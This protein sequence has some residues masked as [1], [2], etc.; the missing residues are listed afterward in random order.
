MKLMRFLP[1]FRKAY[2]MLEMLEARESWSRDEIEAFQLDRVNALWEQASR[3]VPYYRTLAAESN[4][5]PRFCSLGEFRATVPVLPKFE[6]RARRDSF[7]SEKAERGCWEFTSGSTGTPTPV[8]WGKEAKHRTL[9]AQ[10][11]FRAMWG[12][13]IFDRMAVLWGHAASFAP[14]LAGLAARM[15]MPWRDWLRNWI[16]LSAYY[17][18]R[19]DLRQYLRQIANFRPAAIYAYSTAAYLLALEAQA[20]GFTCDSLKMVNL[21]AEPVF[22]YM[23]E[24]VE[25][26]FGVPAVTEYGSVECGF[27][28]GEWRDR[29]LRVREDGVLMET[30]PRNDGRYDIV[31]SVLSNPSFPL[32][33]YA[34]GDVTSAALEFPERGFAILTNVTGRYNDLV[35]SRSGRYIHPLRLDEVFEHKDGIRRWRVQQDSSGTL[36][37][38]IE[39]H[40]DEVSIDRGKLVRELED[41]VE[42]FAV[43]LQVATTLPKT[44]AG[45]H[46][47]ITSDLVN[48]PTHE[49]TG[50]IEAPL[51]QESQRSI[52]DE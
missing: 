45:K 40:N 15:S 2:R 6:V 39:L 41:V 52:V 50:G 18:G 51:V 49:A 48:Q 21:A 36:S 4:L 46:R 20:T 11:R 43:S 13:D 32:I 26:A 27:L 9:R 10:Y 16:R 30:L 38:V 19:D 14:G 23:A 1:R 7:F 37:V 47:W 24:A 3:H 17:L 12:I 25:R 31:V 8:Y 34:I 33:R 35:L 28:A 44:A 5:P 42:G 22:P 29:K